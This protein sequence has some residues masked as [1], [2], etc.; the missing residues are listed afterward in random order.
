MGRD[1]ACG[2]RP[3]DAPCGGA[4]G[5]ARRCRARPRRGMALQGAL[6]PGRQLGRRRAVHDRLLH[7][8]RAVLD[9]SRRGRRRGA[10]LRERAGVSGPDGRADLA[11]GC[12]QPRPRRDAGKR[13]GVPR[14]GDG[15]QR[16]ARGG[17]PGPAGAHRGA[18]APPLVVG[19]GP[20][21]RPVRRA[22]LGPG[23]DG[24]DGPR[25]RCAPARS[26]A[27]GRRGDRSRHSGE[28]VPGTAAAAAVPHPRAAWCD[29]CG[30]A[31]ARRRGGG[32]AGRE[33]AGRGGRA[34]ALGRV[35]HLLAAAL[36]HL[37]GV[38]DRGRRAG[39][40]VD[41]PGAAQ[42][43]GVAAVRGRGGRHRRVRLAPSPR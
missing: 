15:R 23:G 17:D 20:A 28:A 5:H 35:L 42:P 18:P 13:P 24:A 40:A 26:A 1:G 19:A 37:R 8:C 27:V 29:P 22:Q 7:R 25:G 41:V 11:R 30:R 16:G 6:L 31:A 39:A 21:P 10:V 34:D 12:G 4:G 14:H 32:V 2:R 3:P 33:P 9:G 38:V 43:G 36:R